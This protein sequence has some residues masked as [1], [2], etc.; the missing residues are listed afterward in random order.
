MSGPSIPPKMIDIQKVV[1]KLSCELKIV[2]AYEPV[3]KNSR[4]Q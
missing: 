1:Q 2:A 4:P 3:Q